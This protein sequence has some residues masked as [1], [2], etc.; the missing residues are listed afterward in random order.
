MRKTAALMTLAVAAVAWAGTPA[1]WGSAT[2]AR[3]PVTASP[4]RTSHTAGVPGTQLW[5]AR[6]NGPGNSFSND[7]VACCVA[8]S[9]DGKLVFVTGSSN[10]KYS[11]DWATIAYNAATGAQLWVKRYSGPNMLGD[12]AT[13][14][15]VSPNGGTVYVTGYSTGK[16]TGQDYL[17]TAYSAATGATRWVRTYNGPYNG[18][19][20]ATSVAVSPGGNTLFVTGGSMG[21][22]TD[23]DYVTIAYNAATGAQLWVQRYKSP[24]N[25]SGEAT[26]VAVSP[27]GHT[28]FVTGYNMGKTSNW[29]YATVAYN[30]A[31]GAQLWVKRYNGP[32]NGPDQA[33]S[34][35][36]SPTG[37]TVFVTGYTLGANF[38]DEYT[39]IA[40]DAAT[41]ATRWLRTYN[42]PVGGPDVATKVTVG[43]TGNTVFVTG[44][45]YSRI[46][47]SDYVTIAY[48]AATGAMLWLRSYRSPTNGPSDALSMALS[49]GGSTVY[50][51]GVSYATGTNNDYATVAYSAA[52]GAQL[53]VKRYDGPAHNSDGADSVAVSPVTGA[54]YVT[55][56]SMG[57]STG[58]D[59]LTIGYNG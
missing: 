32:G 19:D 55:G 41:G 53:W 14:L 1:A 40:Y 16:I 46:S 21:S 51:T 11:L 18:M 3:H 27:G 35:A 15:A 25:S 36:A 8:V 10:G 48:S 57:L 30:A 26:S 9:P 17:T 28:V 22:A 42:G 37:G 54:V 24:G 13:S 39:T 29:D 2:R 45:D 59:Y 52:T 50:V 34:V 47:L 44:Y 58:E 6:Y 12:A 56:E 33:L 31:T 20:Q 5:I 43:P 7:D 23:W 4:A 38:S 49:P